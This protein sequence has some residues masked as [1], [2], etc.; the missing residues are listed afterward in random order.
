MRHRTMTFRLVLILCAGIVTQLCS[1]DIFAGPNSPSAVRIQD[2]SPPS[3]GRL[4]AS[5]YPTD[6]HVRILN[7]DQPYSPGKELEPGRYDL[8][9]SA[10]GFI[11]QKCAVQIRA[12]E[13]VHVDFELQSKDRREWRDPL[14][15][16]TFVWIEGGCFQ[17]GSP[18]D[19][20]GR[21]IDEGPVHQVCV[22]GF[23]M[24]RYETTQKA[25]KKIMGENPSRIRSDS[26]PVENVNWFDCLAFIDE[27]NIR[28]TDA[29]YAFP[30]EAQWEYAAR[31]GRHGRGDVGGKEANELGLYDMSGN[32]QEWCGDWY[33]SS[34]KGSGA[35]KNPF[36]PESGSKRVIRGACF[37]S[38]PADL[39]PASRTGMNP[40]SAYDINGLRLVCLSKKSTHGKMPPRI[41]VWKDGNGGIRAKK[42]DASD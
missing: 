5:G 34:Y 19:E 31:G 39:R 37:R 25:W 38:Y 15:G 11:P 41:T 12:G 18:A 9:L 32:V 23:W 35:A 8:L 1:T 20:H 36:G 2:E 16:M 21:W 13:E 3:V 29:R 24:S 33:A 30:T 42:E 22:D 14:T 26:R 28:S 7:H 10:D 40:D 4:Y 27:L 17:M 6:A